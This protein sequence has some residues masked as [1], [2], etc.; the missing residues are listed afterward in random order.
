M[1]PYEGLAKD[2]ESLVARTL[3]HYDQVGD[4]A[5]C[6]GRSFIVAHER[7]SEGIDDGINWWQGLTPGMRQ[8]ILAFAALGVA[9]VRRRSLQHHGTL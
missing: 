2:V 1:T 3:E 8:D 6:I 4:I 7:I 9:V 5:D